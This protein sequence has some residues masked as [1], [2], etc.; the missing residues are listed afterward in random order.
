MNEIFDDMEYYKGRGLNPAGGGWKTGLGATLIGLGGLGT[1]GNIGS[2]NI[3]EGLIGGSI[4]AGLGGLLI[5]LDKKQKGGG[6][7]TVFDKHF[8]NALQSMLKQKQVGGALSPKKLKDFVKKNKDIKIHA[9]DI[10]GKD[11]KKKGR[12]LIKAIEEQS[13]GNI[14]KDIGK[15]VKKGYKSVKNVRDKAVDKLKDFAAG[16]TRFKPSDLLKVASGAVGVAGAASAFIPGIDLVSV[17]TAAGISAGLTGASQI[18]QTSGRGRKVPKEC[19]ETT[20][21]EEWEECYAKY[22]KGLK[23]AGGNISPELL[24]NLGDAAVIASVL[25]ISIYAAKKMLDQAKKIIK[26]RGSGLRL[27]GQ[28]GGML[29]PTL[30]S[31]VKKYPKEAKSVAMFIKSG[32]QIGSG[33]AK[34]LAN[35]LGIAT[36]VASGAY[37]LYNFLKEHPELTEKILSVIKG[38]VSTYLQ[39]GIGEE[40]PKGVTYT[41]SGKIKRDRYSVYYGYYKKTAS[42]L[43]KD[44]FIKKGNKIISKKKSQIGKQNVKYLGK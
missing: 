18:L 6:F 20:S 3:A 31:W 35:I 36:S 10:F 37:K 2:S 19:I 43:T 22:G 28:R 38:G 33:K 7:K 4:L 12:I 44:D 21:S 25:G 17:P 11:W 39:G 29:P 23:L 9:K 40:L 24:F 26:S 8:K 41:K 42:G 5:H 15:A 32:G 16:K 14:F 13:G 30:Q 1:A 27:A 34:K